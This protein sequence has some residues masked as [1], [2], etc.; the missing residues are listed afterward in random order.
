MS[1]RQQRVDFIKDTIKPFKGSFLR[2]MPGTVLVSFES[3]SYAARYAHYVS[4]KCPA[5][6][7]VPDNARAIQFTARVNVVLTIE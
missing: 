6:V 3:L 4:D 7:I 2:E 5:A 1:K